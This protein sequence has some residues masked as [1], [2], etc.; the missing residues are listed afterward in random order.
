[1]FLSG[2]RS[3]AWENQPRFHTTC[4][5]YEFMKKF[6]RGSLVKGSVLDPDPEI[7]GLQDPD[8]ILVLD[9]DSHIFHLK[10]RYFSLKC[11]QQ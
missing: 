2:T 3:S 4:T 11:I 8:I 10:Q 6:T 7:F 1:M 9:Q 5:H